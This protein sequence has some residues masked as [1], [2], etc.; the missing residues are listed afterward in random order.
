MCP[1][2]IKNNKTD[3]DQYPNNIQL[4][5]ADKTLLWS[6]ISDIDI[7]KLIIYIMQIKGICTIQI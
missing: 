6:G 5:C 4:Q 7:V 1:Q 3:N 2:K